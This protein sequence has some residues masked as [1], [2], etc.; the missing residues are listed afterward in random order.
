VFP[1]PLLD[2]FLNA[3]ERHPVSIEA[4]GFHPFWAPELRP[5]VR[6]DE[7]R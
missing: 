5:E 6:D 1:N 3:L 2:A 4:V 7:R